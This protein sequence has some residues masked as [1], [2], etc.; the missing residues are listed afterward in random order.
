MNQSKRTIMNLTKRDI[1]LILGIGTLVA[2]LNVYPYPL[3]AAGAVVIG[4]LLLRL[5]ESPDGQTQEKPVQNDQHI[6][7]R[8]A[9]E[10]ISTKLK[11]GAI[12][13]A[14]DERFDTLIAGVVK[15]LFGEYGDVSRIIK[16]KLKETMNP[17]VEK[18]D[19]GQHT[20]K[21][22]HFLNQLVTEMM[23]DPHALVK[24]L[25]EMMGTEPIKELRTS[26]LFDKYTKY[27]GENI[28][29]DDLEINYDDEPHYRDL[30][31][32]MECED[33]EHS[34]RT[35]EQKVLMFTCDEDE[36]ASLR[37]GIERWIDR[38]NKAWYI[39]SIERANESSPSVRQLLRGDNDLTL[40]E[41]PMAYLRDLTE[42]EVYLLKLQY[43][44]TEIVLDETDIHDDE[45]EVEAKPEAYLA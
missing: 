37:V 40:L 19:F 4:I 32:R 22:E 35:L 28:E 41:T 21:L 3:V 23:K 27:L 31:A 36:D 39:H 11:Q 2:I 26:E 42:M 30:T 13:K 1:G 18:Y 14:I 20:V 25:R 44:R 43:D 34:S 8:S 15:D 24:N 5:S 17:Y 33:G 45:V 38:S 7:R 12:E 9:E 29:T 10:I 16:E 6:E